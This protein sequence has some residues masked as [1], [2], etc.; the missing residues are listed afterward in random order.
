MSLLQCINKKKTIENAKKL[1]RSYTGLKR[2]ADLPVETKVT[3]TYS[4]EPRGYTGTVNKS[5]ENSV[6]R[7]VN[8][9]KI[10]D[11]IETAINKILNVNYR[12]ILINKY[13][14]EYKND[15]LI[16]KL[17][18]SDTE[19]YRQLDNALLWFSEC[20]NNASLVVF[21]DFLNI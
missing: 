7:K 8:A 5:L 11:D 17:N 20:Y 16:I 2:I 10:V 15:Y 19:F 21:D 13:V 1:L 6:I 4:F 14:Y 3:Q 12:V 9:E 18:M